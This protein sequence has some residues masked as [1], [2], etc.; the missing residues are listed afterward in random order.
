MLQADND[1]EFVSALVNDLVAFWSYTKHLHERP[2]HP[3]SQ[4]VIKHFNQTLKNIIDVLL[5]RYN[6]SCL[7]QCI[8]NEALT[9]Y[10]N[11]F[12]STLKNTPQHV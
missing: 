6:I 3:Q 5:K 10:H 4:G 7:T 1:S 2:R 9:I 12:H 8:L 11:T